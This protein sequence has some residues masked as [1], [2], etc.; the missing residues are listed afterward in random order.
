MLTGCL[1]VSDLLV[2]YDRLDSFP[3]LGRPGRLPGRMEVKMG[4]K[5]EAK[6][7]PNGA[8]MGPKMGQGGSETGVLN[9]G[10]KK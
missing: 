8:Q 9:W 5:R 1:E 2:K 7:D 10:A 6:R 3:D 4:S